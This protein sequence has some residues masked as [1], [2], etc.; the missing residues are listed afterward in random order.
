MKD[1]ILA[2]LDQ[3]AERFEELNALLGDAGVINDQ[4]Q[5]R[6]LSKE[7]AEIEPVVQVLLA[8]RRTQADQTASRELLTDPDFRELAEQDIRDADQR[9]VAL[10]VE[11][12]RLMLPKDPNDTCN[13]YLEVRAGTGGDE[14]AMLAAM[15]RMRFRASESAR[16]GELLTV[17]WQSEKL[18]YRVS[19]IHARAAKVNQQI[20]PDL[21]LLDVMMPGELDGLQVCQRIRND[22]TLS[23]TKVV[24]LTARGQVRDR[25]AGQA[26][27]A[28]DY[29]VKPFSPLQLID[30]IERHMDATA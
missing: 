6:K 22:A 28:N 4:P 16:E 9:L 21:V 3:L 14:A 1:S 12:Q 17:Q 7:H 10:E 18:F 29:L 23:A 20:R 25:A 5:F 15:G 13:I 26:A 19:E 30:V 2:R 8:Y 24:L 27:G 11:L